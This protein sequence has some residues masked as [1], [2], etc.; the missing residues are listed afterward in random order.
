MTIGFYVIA[1]WLGLNV[2]VV[3]LRLRASGYFASFAGASPHRN[4]TAREKLQ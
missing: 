3:L 4:E 1:G 2:A